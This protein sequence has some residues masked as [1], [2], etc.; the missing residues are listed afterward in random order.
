MFIPVFWMWDFEFFEGKSPEHSSRAWLFLKV[1]VCV[2]CWTDGR[3]A[4]I[5]MVQ[6][7]SYVVM[8]LNPAR[9]VDAECLKICSWTL[10]NM[11]SC[12]MTDIELLAVYVV[13]SFCCSPSFET[14]A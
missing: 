4:V 12:E 7:A 13:K 11:C 9:T 1:L 5:A 14:E 2:G 3:V 6:T 10:L 8:L